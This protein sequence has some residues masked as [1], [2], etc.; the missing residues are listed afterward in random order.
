MFHQVRAWQG[1]TPWSQLNHPE[2]VK[3]CL[4]PPPSAPPGH[5]G[6]ACLAM[7]HFHRLLLPA[8]CLVW[9]ADRQ[10]LLR[11]GDCC[12]AHHH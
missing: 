11:G 8:A 12:G 4:Y 7:C 6:Q 3:T 2:A 10:Q 5:A 1:E 9:P